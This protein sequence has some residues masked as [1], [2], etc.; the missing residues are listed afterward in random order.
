MP[1]C[2]SGA[3]ALTASLQAMHTTSTDTPPPGLPL[4]THLELLHGLIGCSPHSIPCLPVALDHQV[5][6]AVGC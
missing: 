6:H 4:Y 2:E 3:V 1:A 5:E